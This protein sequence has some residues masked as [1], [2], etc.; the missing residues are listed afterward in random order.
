MRIVAEPIADRQTTTTAA[1]YTTMSTPV[2]DLLLVGTPAG[3]AYAGFNPGSVDAAVS[4]VASRLRL[5]PDE[6]QAGLEEA[7]RQLD[8]YF[9]GARTRFELPLDWSLTSGFRRDVLQIVARIPFGETL[10]YGSIAGTVGSPL[11]VRAV[12][13]ACA[14]NPVP[15]V[16][17]CHRVLRTGGQI[18]AYAG[19][20]EAKRVLLEYERSVAAPSPALAQLFTT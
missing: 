11:A 1:S 15:I 2:G 20:A 12:G 13:T 17:P 9:A 6:S 19:G 18:G 14:T 5:Q 3:L 4:A 8:E 10:T 16:V 7:R